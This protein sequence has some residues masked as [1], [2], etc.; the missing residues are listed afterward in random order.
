MSRDV[1]Q[2][3][4]ASAFSDVLAITDLAISAC[5]VRVEGFNRSRGSAVGA[6]VYQIIEGVARGSALS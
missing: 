4:A 6:A 2:A 1:S 3:R 5:P